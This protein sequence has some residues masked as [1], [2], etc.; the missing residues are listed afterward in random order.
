[1]MKLPIGVDNFKELR[2]GN[3]YVDKTDVI[4]EILKSK[5]KISAYLRP[6]GFGKS[7]FISMLDCF[8]DID[9]KSENKHL[10]DGLKIKESEYFKEFGKYPVIHLDLKTLKYDNFESNFKELQNIM[11]NIYKEKIYLKKVLDEYELGVFLSILNKTAC[12]KVLGW[13][14]QFLSV[15]LERYHHQEV[16]I[17]IDGYDTVIQEGYQN[18]F[19]CEIVNLIYSMLDSCIGEYD[20]VKKVL[21]TGILRCLKTEEFDGSN[22]LRICDLM[23][24]EYNDVFGFTEEETTSLLNDYELELTEDVKKHYGGYNFNETFTYNP[25]SILNY[26]EYRKLEDYSINTSRNILF[27]KLLSGMND[28]DKIII[29]ELLKGESI[30]LEYNNYLTYIDFDKR[31]DIITVLNLLY[32]FGYLTFDKYYIRPVIK[33]KM[34]DFKIP[35]EE[36][37]SDLTRLVQSISG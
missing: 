19:Y 8:F 13:S 1:M 35:N 7:L 31:A 14:L 5:S 4:E 22:H 30:S 3:Y 26:I 24:K 17:L 6:N 21:M 28:Q 23:T 18:G 11:S 36:V 29:E 20:T 32:A 2:E 37:R 34:K 25:R 9:K 12:K 15:F 27:K 33:Y 10:F 16:I